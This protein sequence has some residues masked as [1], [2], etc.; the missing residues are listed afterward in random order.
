MRGEW[1]G[2]GGPRVCSLTSR[3]SVF[4]GSSTPELQ[5][6]TAPTDWT[7]KHLQ[8]RDAVLH[9]CVPDPSWKVEICTQTLW[10]LT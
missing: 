2:E 9:L 8:N 7:W 4:G 6:L 10:L 5:R 3:S 1:G